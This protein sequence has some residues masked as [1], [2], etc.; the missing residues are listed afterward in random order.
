VHAAVQLHPGATTNAA[1]L[2]AFVKERL[3]SVQAPKRIHFVETLPLTA[4][5][6]VSKLEVR[7]RLAASTSDYASNYASY[8]PQGKEPLS[9]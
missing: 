4:N 6:K 7:T 3:G 1:E 8:D 2:Q 9:S 5:G